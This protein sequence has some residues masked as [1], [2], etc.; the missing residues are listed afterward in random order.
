MMIGLGFPFFIVLLHLNE[1]NAVIFSKNLS[2]LSNESDYA[3]LL[4]LVES[5][6]V[7]HCY[8]LLTLHKIFD[9]HYSTSE[10]MTLSKLENIALQT[11]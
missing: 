5:I 10:L 9:E 7:I 6:I 1:S 11:L 4:M 8:K 3:I 2:F